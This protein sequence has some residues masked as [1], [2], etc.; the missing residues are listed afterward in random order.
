MCMFLKKTEEKHTRSQIQHDRKAVEPRML[1]LW[2]EEEEFK[3]LQWI[4][5]AKNNGRESE[6]CVSLW[7]L[8]APELYRKAA[9]PEKQ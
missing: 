2:G 1:L 3:A 9:I 4:F 6:S 7:T 5:S 8:E